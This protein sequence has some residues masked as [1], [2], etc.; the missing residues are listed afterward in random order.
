MPW[1]GS[2]PV[3]GALFRS[4]SY[5]QSETDL[6]VIVTAHLVAPSVPG[7]KMAS[8]LDSRAPSNDVDL[9][10]LGQSDVR[11]N[12]SDDVVGPGASNRDP[13]TGYIMPVD[14]K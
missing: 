1:L 13:P 12:K 5:Q 3:L 10:V 14:A 6:V 7:Q 4:S 2:V 11:K 9:F 8:P